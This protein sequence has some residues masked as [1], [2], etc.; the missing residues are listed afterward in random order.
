MVHP[1]APSPGKDGAHLYLV[2]HNSS[3][4]AQGVICIAPMCSDGV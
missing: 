4:W 1:D 2:A 3:H